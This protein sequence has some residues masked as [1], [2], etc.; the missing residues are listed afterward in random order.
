MKHLL[1][2]CELPKCMLDYE[3]TLNDYDFV[4]YHQYLKDETYRN[5]Y[6]NKRKTH[7][8][9]M[10]ILDNSAYEFFVSGEKFV[11]EDFIRVIKELKP[12]YYIVPDVL[13][14]YQNT[15]ANFMRWIEIIPTIPD[16]QPY[17][18]PQGM[19][20]NEFMVC[21][22]AM[23]SLVHFKNLPKNFCIPFH[24]DFFLDRNQLDD[25]KIKRLI[26]GRRELTKDEEYAYGR[27]VLMDKLT[28]L[29]SDYT[30][31]MLGSHNPIEIKYYD[32]Y[33]NIISF[34]SGYPVKLAISG[35]KLGEEKEKPNVIIDDF[36]GT[37][38]SYHVKELIVHN[39]C[40]MKYLI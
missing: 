12:T 36:Y 18:V 10:M 38:L 34:D 21:A 5:N 31:H 30:F 15:F 2:C 14:D 19:T 13:M 39:I 23:D 17:F 32:I 24:N 4:L 37:D 29:Y 28:S 25:I 16:S 6:L 26:F 27:M 22:H 35:V 8:D 3:D 11:E 33:D 40:E 1:T 9:R 7:P 20:F